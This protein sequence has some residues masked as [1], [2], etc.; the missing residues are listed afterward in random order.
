MII[1]KKGEEYDRSISRYDY[2]AHKNDYRFLA[3]K[4]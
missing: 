4:K 1:H 2:L 3:L